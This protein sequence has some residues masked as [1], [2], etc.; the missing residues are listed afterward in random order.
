M[1]I[2]RLQR[3]IPHLKKLKKASPKQ[4][5]K[6]LAKSK[7]DL[8]NCICDCCLNITK[9]NLKISQAQ[10]KRLVCYAPSI[11]ALAKKRQSVKKRKGI[12]LQKGGF[13]PALLVPV[14][15][16]AASVLGGLL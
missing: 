4:R 8:I 6:L 5:R 16:L 13:L 1:A 14:L 3:N 2:E 15:S 9:G 10:K 11:R 12:L 7:P